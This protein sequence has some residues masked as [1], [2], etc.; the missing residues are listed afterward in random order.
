MHLIFSQMKALLAYWD[1]APR[2]DPTTSLYVWHDQMQTGA[3]DLVM[4]NCPSKYSKC[5][6]EAEDAFTLASVD[7]QMFLSREHTAYARFCTSWAAT[8]VG[9]ER[10]E[11]GALLKEAAAHEAK[12][13]GILDVME[14]FLWSET[15]GVYVGRNMS[16]G[17]AITARTY[18]M[19]MP[20]WG[21]AAPAAHAAK[22]GTTF[23]HV[24]L[25]PNFPFVFGY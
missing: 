19:G 10:G 4:S 20:L 2:K 11:A 15:A 16:S 24:F 17:E 6:N 5:W 9:G 12:A 3:D 18:L 8:A 22:I 14:K 25:T 1:L 7:L 21:G 13:Q 23:Q